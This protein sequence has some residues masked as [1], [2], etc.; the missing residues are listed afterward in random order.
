[1]TATKPQELPVYD[2]AA[3]AMK[4]AIAEVDKMIAETTLSKLPTPTQAYAE[5]L[6][7]RHMARIRPPA[8]PETPPEVVE[9]ALHDLRKAITEGGIILSSDALLALGE[10]SRLRAV[11]DSVKQLTEIQ[12][13]QNRLRDAMGR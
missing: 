2:T 3:D 10:I 4:G 7:A 8:V 1:M 9:R 6:V 5:A 13:A 12:A 11:I